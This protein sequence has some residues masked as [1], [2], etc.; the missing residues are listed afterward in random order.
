M[1]ASRAIYTLAQFCGNSSI[2][3][4]EGGAVHTL[5]HRLWLHATGLDPENYNLTAFLKKAVRSWRQ[6]K[7]IND[8]RL[9]TTVRNRAEKRR[10]RT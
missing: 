9:F 8:G 3:S 6:G 2:K 7:P 5:I 10:L 4:T 1:F